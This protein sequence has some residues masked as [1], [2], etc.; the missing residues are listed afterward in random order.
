MKIYQFFSV[1]KGKIKK[2]I[3]FGVLAG[4]MLLMLSFTLLNPAKQ[5]RSNLTGFTI[6]SLAVAAESGQIL[7]TES[8][9]QNLISP[10]VVRVVQHIQGTARIPTFIID[11]SKRTIIVDKN[12]DTTR[13]E[14]LDQNIIGS[15][16]IVSPNGHIL[17]NAHLVSDMASKLAIIAPYMREDIL[18][19][20]DVA[21]GDVEKDKMFGIE[22]RDFIIK[23]SVFE[24]EKEIVILNPVEQ[25]TENTKEISSEN[26]QLI[27]PANI[28]YVNNNFYKDNNNVAIIKIENKNLPSLEITTTN[29]F[30]TGEKL[31]TLEMPTLSN[32]TNLNDFNNEGAYV[33]NIKETFV[34][35]SKI[36]Q[37]N[38]YTKTKFTAE[39]SGSPLFNGFGKIVGILTSEG[40]LSYGQPINMFVVLNSDTQP[41]LARAGVMS[42]TGSYAKHFKKGSEYANNGFCDE[43]NKEFELAL[44]NKTPFTKNLT[45]SLLLP[46]CDPTAK[47]GTHSQTKKSGF[48]SVIQNKF[49]TS[50]FL[51]GFIAIL[52]VFLLLTLLV[53][54]VVLIKSF[55][56]HKS[57][58][59]LSSEYTR[60]VE[61]VNARR[62][63]LAEAFPKSLDNNKLPT[64]DAHLTKEESNKIIHPSTQDQSQHTTPKDEQENLAQLWPDKYT[65]QLDST[66]QKENDIENIQQ[67]TNNEILTDKRI[68]DYI[69][70]TQNQGFSEQDIR[71]ELLRVGWSA[72]DI[73]TAFAY[74][75]NQ[76]ENTIT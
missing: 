48:L 27:F 36:T 63:P 60:G 17:T 67:A 29:T 66:K 30:S 72:N 62:K 14:N 75:K 9:L 16:V 23:N 34:D 19:A 44:S 46:G 76:K 40:Q 52:V 54:V 42:V 7:Y 47:T 61:V 59:S 32:F 28:L 74:I 3:V 13:V 69:E 53:A 43:S 64:T 33:F 1:Q 6:T 22:M 11:F 65:T 51:D 24:L 57:T 50:D 58:T 10:S 18:K 37:N 73:D 8:Q 41:I 26:K 68:T 45:T 55:K 39:T 56:K 5:V 71:A 2:L 12:K 38:I 35:T 70:E 20:G 15:G 25:I 31:Y 21:S 49:A 4:V